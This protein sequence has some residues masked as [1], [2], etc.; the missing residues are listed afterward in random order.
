MLLQ[1]RQNAEF[2]VAAPRYY[3]PGLALAYRYVKMT[4]MIESAQEAAVVVSEWLA[5]PAPSA[6]LYSARSEHSLTD[7]ICHRHAGRYNMLM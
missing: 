7:H 5:E 6:L 3:Q 1:M 4:M 2:D